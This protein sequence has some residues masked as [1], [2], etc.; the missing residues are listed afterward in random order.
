FSASLGSG[1]ISNAGTFTKSAGSGTSAVPWAFA[2]SGTLQVQRGTLSFTRP[3]TV[4]GLGILTGTLP[5]AVRVGAAWTGTTRNADLYSPQI[6]MTFTG[7]GNEFA[8]QL[9]EAMSQDLGNTTPGFQRN[10]A[11]GTLAL[12]QGAYLR[13]VDNARNASGTG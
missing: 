1:T 11:Y 8:P 10:F 6:T 3:V 2:N 13:L 5:G 9:L 7:P 4:D 12:D